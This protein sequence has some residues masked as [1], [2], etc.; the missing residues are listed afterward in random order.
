[1]TTPQQRIQVLYEI[2]LSVGAKG[3]LTETARTALSAY[4]R[5]L[6]C[7]AGAVFER[8]ADRSGDVHYES[9]AMI[10]SRAAV[11]NGLDA[12]MDELPDGGADD[13]AFRERL[14]R[15]ADSGDGDTYY[16][17]SLP[18]FGVL[19]LVTRQ[20]RLDSGTV[21]ALRRVNEKLATA[22][23]GDRYED[24]LDTE[25][26][27]FETVFATIDEPLAS[28][29]PEDGELLVRRVNPAFESTF[30]YDERDALDRPLD[31]LLGHRPTADDAVPSPSESADG[32]SSVTT[33]I[34]RETPDGIGEFLF[35]SAPI[36]PDSEDSEHLVLLVD[37][38]EAV[39]RQRRLERFNEVTKALSR[40]LRHNI[41]NDLTVIQAMAERIHDE[42]EGPPAADARTILR[43][44]EQLGSTAEKARE[45]RELVATHERQSTVGLRTAV[46]GAVDP[47][48]TTYP[49]AEITTD[50]TLEDDIE[51]H[52]TIGIAVRHLVENGI[53]HRDGERVPR[54]SVSV[55]PHPDGATVTVCD[56]GSGIPESEVEMLENADETP[57]K[58][59]SGAGLWIVGQIVDYCDAMLEFSTEDGG[60][61]AVLTIERT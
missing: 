9:V 49:H 38:T 43:K 32:E 31:E 60:T 16:L 37:I 40:I 7:S 42:T 1:M 36:R 58:H 27:R 54:V 48:T 6:N 35:R 30:G 17:M 19:V 21:A 47:L 22:C 29:R 11:S 39:Q 34:R 3:D 23:R 4:L 20:H 50:I 8:R 25:R 44:S 41:R 52:P 2:S 18:D 15:T 33:K 10:P 13:T 51:V 55:E 5:K 56:N 26:G 24:R 61:T 53:E 45:M 12:A 46:A 14:P 28:V 57:L 59:G